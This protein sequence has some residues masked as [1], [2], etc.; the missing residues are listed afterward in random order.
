MSHQFLEQQ[1][2]FLTMEEFKEK[3]FPVDKL[4]LKEEKRTI[5]FYNL[6]TEAEK[7]RFNINDYFAALT[8]RLIFFNFRNS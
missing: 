6:L 5:I 2:L 1:S 4:L 3:L 7:E 8:W